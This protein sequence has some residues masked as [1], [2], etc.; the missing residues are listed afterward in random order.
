MT[1]HRIRNIDE[2]RSEIRRMK[3]RAND[4]EKRIA[5]DI[6]AIRESLRPENILIRALSNITGIQIN[7]SEFLKN[8]VLM[9]IGLLLQRFAF[10][11]ENALEHKVYHWV[12]R[13]FN[14]LKS[15]VARFTSS[16]SEKVDAE[17]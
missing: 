11:S 6:Q 12:D 7:K 10:K 4:Q 15:Y 16:R 13:L 5:E 9:G 8:G 17:S 2:L 3:H 1:E 14:K